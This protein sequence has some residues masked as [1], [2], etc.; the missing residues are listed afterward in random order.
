MYMISTVKIHKV[1]VVSYNKIN[2]R[3]GEGG[4]E[5]TEGWKEGEKEKEVGSENARRRNDSYLIFAPSYFKYLFFVSEYVDPVNLSLSIWWSLCACL[6]LRSSAR[7][8]KG[9]KIK[10]KKETVSN[11]AR[12]SSRLP[13]S[14]VL[15]AIFS[16][17]ISLFIY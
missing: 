8:R 4:V 6:L 3:R 17:C 7:G 9:R 2:K 13:F 16:I 1:T 12:Q 5:V 15:L 10:Q 11:L 14:P